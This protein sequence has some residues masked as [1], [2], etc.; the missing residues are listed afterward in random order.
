[1][2]CEPEPLC[3]K[4]LPNQ[5]AVVVVDVTEALRA[6]V[7]PREGRPTE[8]LLPALQ[9]REPTVLLPEVVAVVIVVEDVVR[10]VL[11]PRAVVLLR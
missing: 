11:P 5:V 3:L 6:V 8:L 4:A 7:S 2:C 10:Q 1:M 9:P